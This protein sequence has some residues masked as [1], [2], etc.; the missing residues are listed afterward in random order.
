[1]I[2]MMVDGA[3]VVLVYSIQTEETVV[4]EEEEDG[5]MGQTMVVVAG[6][7]SQEWVIAATM[8]R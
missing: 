2:A 8:T 4:V 3:Q 7:G 1:M 6:E 5:K